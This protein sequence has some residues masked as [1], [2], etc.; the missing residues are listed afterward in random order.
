VTH[1]EI[2]RYLLAPERRWS[3]L[4]KLE[5]QG[6]Q[7]VLGYMPVCPASGVRRGPAFSSPPPALR[8]LA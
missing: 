7:E 6:Y 3:L 1:L 8:A 4:P 2:Y 5:A